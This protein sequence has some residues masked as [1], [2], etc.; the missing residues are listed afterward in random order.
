VTLDVPERLADRIHRQSFS[1]QLLVC[2]SSR[3]HT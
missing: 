3:L 2:I 1:P